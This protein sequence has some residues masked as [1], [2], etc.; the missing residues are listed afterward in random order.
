MSSGSVKESEGREREGEGEN[1][2][3]ENIIIIIMTTVSH[4]HNK[5]HPRIIPFAPSGSNV[6]G[7]VAHM[8]RVDTRESSGGAVHRVSFTHS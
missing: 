6:E 8:A 7:S 5:K 1:T 3:E 2:K 4:A